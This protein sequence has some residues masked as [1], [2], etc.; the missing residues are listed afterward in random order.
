L[1]IIEKFKYVLF[2]TNVV[3]EKVNR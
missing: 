1:I 3:Q 2:V